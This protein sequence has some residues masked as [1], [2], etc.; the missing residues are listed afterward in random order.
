MPP[1]RSPAPISRS[2]AAG[3]RNEQNRTAHTADQSRAGPC[4]RHLF[5]VVEPGSPAKA[6]G[7]SMSAACAIAVNRI[8]LATVKA[9]KL[10]HGYV[11]K[12]VRLGRL[13][14]RRLQ[15]DLRLV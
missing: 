9:R 6:A 8:R 1:R 11:R 13:V 12:I 4:A 14:C 5:R 2:T 15:T 10:L 3:R 7:A